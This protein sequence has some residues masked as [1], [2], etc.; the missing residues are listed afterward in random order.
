VN[1]ADLP[2]H[3]SDVQ[4][5]FDGT[6]ILV[7]GKAESDVFG[8]PLTVGFSAMA[9]PVMADGGKVGVRLTDVRAID[10]TLP[11]VFVPALEDVINKKLSEVAHL[12]DYRVRDVE[13]AKDSL[14]VYLQWAPPGAG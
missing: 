6:G 4:A 2:F 10:G 7:S 8:V 9:H 3:A 12:D 13:M 11:A 5:S 14:L 1:E